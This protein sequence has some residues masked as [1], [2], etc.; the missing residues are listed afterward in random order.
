[1]LWCYTDYSDELWNAPPL[2]LALHERSFG[3]WRADSTPKPSVA[4]VQAFAQTS[5]HL[6]LA[7]P[8]SLATWLDIDKEEFY[9]APEVQLPRLYTRYCRSGLA[10]PRK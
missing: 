10:E 3:L 2:D 5:S 9:D 8:A 4:A 1:M 7:Q 6:P